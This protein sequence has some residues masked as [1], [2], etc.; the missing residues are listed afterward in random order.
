MSRINIED[1]FLNVSPRRSSI[2]IVIYVI[3]LIFVS[4]I[5]T[6]FLSS[7]LSN[8]I[9]GK[10]YYSFMFFYAAF[11]SVITYILIDNI[12][13]RTQLYFHAGQLCIKRS[14]LLRS[15]Q[16]LGMQNNLVAISE[17]R[18]SPVP[19]MDSNFFGYGNFNVFIRSKGHQK[20]VFRGLM[21]SDADEIVK[22][23]NEKST[24]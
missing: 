9:P 2:M 14:L 23:I 8:K 15:V 18:K 12:F 7:G 22:F 1:E 17:I 6:K 4:F 21:K 10:I 24:F 5:M 13:G 20:I 11:F 19:L 16:N 3:Q